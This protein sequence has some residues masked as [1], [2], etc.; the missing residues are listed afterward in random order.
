MFFSNITSTD[1]LEVLFLHIK[2]VPVF[3]LFCFTVHVSIFNGSIAL[4]A[5]ADFQFPDLFTVG[6]IYWTSDELVARPLPK[7]RTAQTK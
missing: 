1:L 7:H 2:L 3:L 4:V 5:L 6:R